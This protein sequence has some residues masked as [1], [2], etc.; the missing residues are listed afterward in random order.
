[1]FNGFYRTSSHSSIVIC[2]LVCQIFIFDANVEAQFIVDLRGL[3]P[4]TCPNE[5]LET[6]AGLDMVG[7]SIQV[8]PWL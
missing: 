4:F 2:D 6:W 7:M 5:P 1:M 8:I 3:T